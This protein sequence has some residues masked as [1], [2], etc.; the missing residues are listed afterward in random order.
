M[1]ATS[2]LTYLVG[3]QSDLDDVVFYPD[4]GLRL[5]RGRLEPL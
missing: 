2:A 1:V 4:A 3:G 5:V